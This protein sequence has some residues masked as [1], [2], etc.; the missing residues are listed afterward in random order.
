MA[1]MQIH[2]LAVFFPENTCQ[3]L[4]FFVPEC[5]TILKT[6]VVIFVDFSKCFKCQSEMN[7]SK[8]T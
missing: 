8:E 3:T 2:L 7:K 6:A 5:S 4:E 1:W